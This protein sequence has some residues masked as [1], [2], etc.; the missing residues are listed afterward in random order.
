[1]KTLHTLTIVALAVASLTGC[2]AG[3][4][5][6]VNTSSP[7][8]LRAESS[9]TLCN[10]W[11]FMH[12]DKVRAELERRNVLSAEEWR[13]IDARRVAIGMSRLALLCSWGDPG[14]SGAINR[15]VTA[16]GVSEQWVY[17]D[18]VAKRTRYIYVRDGK[19]V[20][21]QD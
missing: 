10:A 13:L 2:V 19:V 18:A 7:E 1:M 6:A 16:R 14:Y 11:G 3:A 21:M 12:T 4:P 17:R 20:T 9:E 15:T 5:V 8:A